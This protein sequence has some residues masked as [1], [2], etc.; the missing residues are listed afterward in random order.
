MIFKICSK[1]I[2]EQQQTSGEF[3]GVPLDTKDGYIHFSTKE[4]LAETLA[5][6]FRGQRDLVVFAVDENKMP[7]LKWE[8]A[9]GGK[10]FPHAYGTFPF[11]DI[12]HKAEVHVGEDGL[13]S[14][15]TWA[16]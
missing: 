3:T 8:E 5:V 7:N 6:H 15:P 11:S 9:R 2:F 10:L 13:C 4:T 1:A 16:L 12:V 14:L